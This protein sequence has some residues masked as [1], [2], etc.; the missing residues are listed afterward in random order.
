MCKSDAATARTVV[1]ADACFTAPAVVVQLLTGL[2][3][4]PHHGDT[5]LPTIWI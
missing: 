1:I 2:L 5:A 3:A 4:D